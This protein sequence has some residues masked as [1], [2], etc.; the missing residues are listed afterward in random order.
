MPVNPI[1]FELVP[2]VLPPDYCFQSFQRL[3]LDMFSRASVTFRTNITNVGYNTDTGSPPPPDQRIF[4]W[5]NPTNGRWYIWSD[6]YG[7]WISPMNPSDRVDGFRRMWAPPA[8]TLESAL[9][10]LDEGDGTDPSI[11]APTP[12][13]GAAWEVDHNLDGRFPLASGL[14]PGT[15][16]TVLVGLN[17]GALGSGIGSHVHPFG[18]TNRDGSSTSDDAYF[19]RAT[20]TTVP[21]YSGWYVQG[22]GDATIATLTEADLFTL[23]AQSSGPDTDQLPPYRTIYWVKPTA[24]VYYTLPG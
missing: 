7:L 18:L 10:S 24:K 16:T 9:W 13:S 22:G 4:P 3:A 19:A 17:G 23:P 15:S 2:P 12:V 20:L 14:I 8:G 11:V 6:L 21:S 5:L 1:V